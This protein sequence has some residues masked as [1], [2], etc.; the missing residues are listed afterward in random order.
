MHR[1]EIFLFS[2]TKIAQGLKTSF[3]CLTHFGGNPKRFQRAFIFFLQHVDSKYYPNVLGIEGLLR[4]VHLFPYFARKVGE[5]VRRPNYYF[6][7][8]LNQ[9]SGQ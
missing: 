8:D 3:L 2:L 6:D 4:F 9:I 1:E 7:E 5:K